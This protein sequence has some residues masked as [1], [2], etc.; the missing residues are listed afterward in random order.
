MAPRRARNST[1]RSR[2]RMR[3]ASRTGA[4]LTSRTSLMSFS[5][6]R[7]PAWITSIVI[8]PASRTAIWSATDADQSRP[9]ISACSTAS[10]TGF[11]GVCGAS[12]DC[13]SGVLVVL[14]L[15]MRGKSFRLL[16][17]RSGVALDRRCTARSAQD[18]TLRGVSGGWPRVASRSVQAKQWSFGA[19]CRAWTGSPWGCNQIARD[20]SARIRSARKTRAGSPPR[21]TDDRSR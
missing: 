10:V 8:S 11:C 2:S 19:L 17:N 9:C 13:S 16:G 14:S 6:R 18:L 3:K 20:T 7:W 21:S 12:S 1:S 15:P 5:S 4:R